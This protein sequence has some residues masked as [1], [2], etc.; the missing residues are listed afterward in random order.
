M[1]GEEEMCVKEPKGNKILG[2]VGSYCPYKQKDWVEDIQYLPQQQSKASK[3]K[4]AWYV[5]INNPKEVIHEA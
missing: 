1:G 2:T 4:L 3:P 5:E